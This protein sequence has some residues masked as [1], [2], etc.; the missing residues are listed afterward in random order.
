MIPDRSLEVLRAIVE[1]F[2]TSNQP[3]GSKA[4]L[5]RH[6]LGVS[7]ATVRNDMALLEDEELITAVHTSSGR[8][9]TEKGYRLFVDR[10]AEV[11]S[12]RPAERQAIESF[13]TEATD[14]DD[15]VDRAARALAQL[16]NALAV[17][18]YPSLGKS[19]VRHIELLPLENN[20][21]LLMLI[22]DSG[23]VQQLTVD[24]GAEIAEDLVHQL[25]GHLNGLLVGTQLAEVEQKLVALPEQFAPERRDFVN[26]VVSSLQSLVDANRQE[27][28]VLSGAANLV[29]RDA[30]F[31]GELSRILDAIEE[32]VVMLKLIDELHAD[33]H[34]VGIRIGSEL[35][36]T[37]LASAS[38]VMT[39][40]ESH[41]TEVAKLGVLG[42]T[43][44]D[45]SGGISAV[46]AVARYVS[47]SFEGGK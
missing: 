46:R 23:R 36:F 31:N 17:V 28:L 16:T 22:L 1:D 2:V 5:E 24:C 42:P 10:L 30:D 14:L 38:I 32:Q 41:G 33:S 18:Q 26:S 40:Y 13:L 29:R 11:R 27:K 20:R 21:L 44:M 12:L 6:P 43:R 4:L 8:I 35:G 25:R 45:Y 7:A 19:G 9:P 3:V 37:G 34:G 39:G 15:V 47:K